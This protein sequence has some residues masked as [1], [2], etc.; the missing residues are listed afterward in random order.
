M[1]RRSA[2]SR[3]RSRPASPWK[4]RS[5]RRSRAATR[6]ASPA[7]APSARSRRSTSSAPPTPRCTSGKTY[8]F[9]IIEYKDGGKIDRRL[10][11]QAARRGAAGAARR[12]LRKSIVPGAVLPGR[13][14]SVLDFGA[15]VDLGGGIQGLL[16]VSEMSWSRVTTPGEMV[17]RRRPDHRQGAARG[18]GHAED[19]ARAEAAA[20]RSVERR[21]ARPTRWARCGP[22]A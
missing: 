22:A 16:H 14:A 8:T 2:S 18:R 17:A 9:R 6:C 15:F 12:T 13:V 11:A 5:R 7:S 3:T 4:A 20:G 19:F 10:A 21:S 1:P